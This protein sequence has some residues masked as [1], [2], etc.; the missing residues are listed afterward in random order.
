MQP[1]SS[2]TLSLGF[3]QYTIL[4]VIFAHKCVE[5]VLFAAYKYILR[6]NQIQMVKNFTICTDSLDVTI[7][8][9]FFLFILVLG[10]FLFLGLSRCLFKLVCCFSLLLRTFFKE[11]RKPLHANIICAV[12]SSFTYCT[13]PHASH[14]NAKWWNQKIK[15]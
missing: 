9:L 13:I 7:R 12:F 8:N 6:V 4:N 1:T 3:L 11:H 10:L 5:T 15:K 2:L 14:M